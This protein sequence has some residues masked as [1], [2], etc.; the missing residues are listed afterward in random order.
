M[1]APPHRH[2]E[3]GGRRGVVCLLAGPVSFQSDLPAPSIACGVM[4]RR[5]FHSASCRFGLFGLL[6]RHLTIA[7]QY[8]GGLCGSSWGRVSVEF[9]YFPACFV[10][11]AAL[12]SFPQ[13]PRPVARLIPS[14][15]SC[16]PRLPL[17]VPFCLIRAH[18]IP[19]HSFR[20]FDCFAPIVLIAITPR[21]SCRINGADFL[22][23]SNSMPLKSGLRSG[24]FLA[25][26]LPSCGFRDAVGSSHHLIENASPSTC[27]PLSPSHHG[28]GLRTEPLL[29]SLPASRPARRVGERGGGCAWMSSDVMRSIP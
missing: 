26:C 19:S 23:A 17:S 20:P 24:S 29:P 1:F 9:D 4:G 16:L 21:L 18:P 2:G 5:R 28:V 12:Y 13:L 8:F 6:A 10:S 3:R 25:A 7:G 27:L 22:N 14:V 15:P 11:P